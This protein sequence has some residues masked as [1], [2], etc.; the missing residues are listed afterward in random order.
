M[1]YLEL[2]DKN[3]EKAKSDHPRMQAGNLLE[4]A[5][6]R[7]IISVRYALTY[8]TNRMFAN[9]P[10]NDFLSKAVYRALSSGQ[11][12]RDIE[13]LWRCIVKGNPEEIKSQLIKMGAS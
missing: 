10:E 11:T 4:L 12:M 1:N 9:L 5:R 7:T 13:T 2:F 6:E 3:L 8:K